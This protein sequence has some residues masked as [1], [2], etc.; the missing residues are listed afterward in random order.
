MHPEGPVWGATATGLP[1]KK[2][3]ACCSIVAK[4]ELMS[5][6]I[7]VGGSGLKDESVN[8]SIG[9]LLH[10]PFKGVGIANNLEKHGLGSHGIDMKESS[11]LPVSVV[12]TNSSHGVF[13]VFPD[14]DLGESRFGGVIA[15]KVNAD[16]CFGGVNHTNI[17]RNCS[18]TIKPKIT[19][20]QANVLWWGT[21]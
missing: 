17:S 21:I 20:S 16:R 11:T 6:C 9:D 1:R 3:L 12:Q 14:D 18:F 5:R 15:K 2:G 4:Q 7:Q 19:R 13:P 8:F 10:K